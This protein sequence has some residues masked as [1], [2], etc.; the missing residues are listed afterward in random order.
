[1]SKQ[2]KPK[3]ENVEKLKKFLIKLNQCK[4]S[5]TSQQK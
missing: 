3:E 2:Y 5:T 1:M 4:D